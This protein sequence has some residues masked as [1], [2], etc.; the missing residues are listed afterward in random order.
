MRTCI[1]RSRLHASSAL[2]LPCERGYLGDIS[3]LVHRLIETIE[4]S[5]A[6]SLPCPKVV[7][8]QLFAHIVGDMQRPGRN[9]Q[10][11]CGSGRKYKHCCLTLDETRPGRIGIVRSSTSLREKNL[12]LLAATAD[13]FRLNLPW[14]KVKSGMSDA[15][16]REFYQFVAAL[17]HRH[18][19]QSV[20][21]NPGYV[22]ACSL[23]GGV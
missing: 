13:I 11:D 3:S 17:S 8:H 22:S 6:I 4:R 9:E 2:R 12:A 5:A 18:G 7:K 20:V 10:C 1:D 21:A 15:R 19:L 16:I 14:E 23:S